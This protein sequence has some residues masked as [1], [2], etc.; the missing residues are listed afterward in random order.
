RRQSA[1]NFRSYLA[2][3]ESHTILRSSQFYRETSGGVPFAQ[4]FAAL[5]NGSPP[6]NSACA[7]C[8]TRS[9]SCPF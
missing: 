4:W 2:S 9:T 6:D 5:L 8:L 3:G 7:D 1:G